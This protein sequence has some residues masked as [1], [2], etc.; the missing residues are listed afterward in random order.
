MCLKTVSMA[1]PNPVKLMI[2][3]NHHLEAKVP[4]RYLSQCLLPGLGKE[5]M[6]AANLFFQ[7]S[8]NLFFFIKF[9]HYT[10][11]LVSLSFFSS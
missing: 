11:V 4:R 5:G 2:K 3:V 10:Q 7:P 1:I 9:L 6:Y 8:L